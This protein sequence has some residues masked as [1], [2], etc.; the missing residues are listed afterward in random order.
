MVFGC[1]TYSH[2]KEDKL[3]PRARKCV[4]VGFKKSVKGYKVWDSKDKKFILSKVITFDEISIIKATNSQY[5]K[6]KKTKEISQ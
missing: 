6:S 3:H 5:V 1:P 4:F 2:V